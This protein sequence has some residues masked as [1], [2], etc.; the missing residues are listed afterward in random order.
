[1]LWWYEAVASG[2]AK[3]AGGSC[4]R[5]TEAR[6]DMLAQTVKRRFPAPRGNR[7]DDAIQ[8]SA[9][10]CG[11]YGYSWA[12]AA[13][14]RLAACRRRNQLALLAPRPNFLPASRPFRAHPHAVLHLGLQPADRTE[15]P[16]RLRDKRAG[17]LRRFRPRANALAELALELPVLRERLRRRPADCDPGAIGVG[18]TRVDCPARLRWLR[19]QVMALPGSLLAGRISAR[20]AAA[21]GSCALAACNHAFCMRAEITRPCMERMIQDLSE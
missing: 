21:A 15:P 7:C 16:T 14:P 4:T 2:Q 3:V 10:F 6:L 13:P 11:L 8:R 5:L 9:T 12:A 1:M 20:H 17:P 18:S 19:H